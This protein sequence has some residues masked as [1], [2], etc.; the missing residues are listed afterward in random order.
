MSGQM[1]SPV[2]IKAKE[3]IVRMHTH[4]HVVELQF[5]AL[6]WAITKAERINKDASN[7]ATRRDISCPS[8]VQVGRISNSCC[9][10]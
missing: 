1:S 7:A 8:A 5:G 9:F 10:F 6:I 4:C 3:C 2:Q